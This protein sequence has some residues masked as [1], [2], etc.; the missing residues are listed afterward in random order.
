MWNRQTFST[1]RHDGKADVLAVLWTTY[2]KIFVEISKFYA[3]K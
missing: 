1:Y 3:K 2:K